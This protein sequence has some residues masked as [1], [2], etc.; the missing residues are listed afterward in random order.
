M[1][2]SVLNERLGEVILS[3]LKQSI[4]PLNNKDIRIKLRNLSHRLSEYEIINE[5]R[6]LQKDGL[7]RLEKGSWIS[8]ASSAVSYNEKEKQFKKPLEDSPKHKMWTPSQCTS[9]CSTPIQITT[10][11]KETPSSEIKEY[12]F[13][14]HWGTFRR[15]LKYYSD[16]VRNDGGCE[17]SGYL[18]DYQKKFLFLNQYG[19]WYPQ[20]GQRWQMSIQLGPSSQSFLKEL[21]KAGDH[22]VLVLGYPFQVFTNPNV[23]GPEGVYVRPIFTYQLSWQVQEGR[24]VI[25]NDDPWADINLDWLVYALKKPEEQRMFLA[26]CGLMARGGPDES[27]G[28]GSRI[29]T[30]PDL[31]T[32]ANGVTA[33]IGNRLKEALRPEI[34]SASPLAE[35]PESGIYNRAV[36]MIASRTKYTNSLLKDLKLIESM[37][38]ADFDNTALRHVFKSTDNNSGHIEKDEIIHEGVVLDTCDLNSEQ[39]TAV[40]SL[41]TEN[42]SVITGPPGTGKS[43]VVSASLMNTRLKEEAALFTSRNHKALDAVL[44]RMQLDQSK[45]VIIRANS[46][47]DPFLKFDCESALKQLLTEEHSN[48]SQEQWEDV[49]KKLFEHLSDRGKLGTLVREVQEMRDELGKLEQS[50]TDLSADWDKQFRNELDISYNNFPTSLLEQINSKLRSLRSME[51]RPSLFARINWLIQDILFIRF[52]TK[53]INKILSDKFNSWKL[54]DTGLG[55]DRLKVIADEIT[56]LLKASQYCSD[57]CKAVPIA[58]QLNSKPSLEDLTHRMKEISDKLTTLVPSALAHHL[59][60]KTGLPRDADRE[61]MANLKS[62]LRSLNHPL[63]DDES[64]RSVQTHLKQLMPSLIK[65]Y[66]L[67]SV[68]NLAI[69][70]RI[71]LMPGLFDLAIIDEAS[72]CDIASAIPI[73]F[74]AKRVGVVGDP[75]QLS[76]TTKLSRP[77]DILIR[78]RHGLVDLSQQ[79]FSYVDTSLYDLFA[80]TNYISPVFLRDTYRSIDII[81]DYS[82]NNFYEGKLRVAT[83]VDKLRVPHG[84]K[85][86]IHWTDITSEIKSGG[87]SGCFAP[88]E[89]KEIVDIVTNILV[90]NQFEGTLGIVTPFRQQANRINDMIYQE[91]PVEKLRSAQVIV[92]TAHGF[93]GDERDVIILSLCAGP[94]MPAGSRG[95]IRETAN[96]M[97]VAVSRARAVLHI[98]GNKIWAAKSGIPHIASLAN[99]SKRTNYCGNTTQS[100]W[101]PHES[102]WEKILFEA[103]RDKGIDTIPQYPV[104]GRRLDLAIVQKDGVKIDIEVDGDQYHRNPDGTRKHDDVWRDIQLQGAGWKVIRFWVYQL[105]EDMDSCINKILKADNLQ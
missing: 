37:S 92:D 101:H 4:F 86:G 40:S 69:G 14:G 100:K 51:S 76:H 90:N 11:T 67:W 46:K 42:V 19:H 17:A 71:P 97:N 63:S 32:L 48:I 93:Q 80:Q 62:A 89:I 74:R 44:Y 59:S 75:H 91:I 99:P 64:R 13:T 22:G 95:F 41:L 34:V 39:R 15:L 36:L 58:D 23:E 102:P 56:M 104:L 10:D 105:R 9:I 16:C 27:T 82:N 35:R 5:L 45:P 87:P 94:D 78:K 55:Y 53:K 12:D 1:S 81:A 24:L 3:I 43:Q 57:R 85:A 26:T 88:A 77:R 70:S 38:D 66:P 65:H 73:M 49:K 18:T 28:D 60:S 8:I 31:A 21:A 68:T 98:V 33:S 84:T 83:A 47:E 7:V 25:Y 29:V 79:R 20:A 30:A 52:K 103:L 54:K 50:M 2:V 72:Q 61:E 6:L 96:L